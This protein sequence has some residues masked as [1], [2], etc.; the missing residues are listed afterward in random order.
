MLASAWWWC[1][2]SA[3]GQRC[4]LSAGLAN[5]DAGLLWLW[6][7][8]RHMSQ[9]NVPLYQQHLAMKQTASHVG[10]SKWRGLYLLRIACTSLPI[11]RLHSHTWGKLTHRRSYHLDKNGYLWR[12]IIKDQSILYFKHTRHSMC[13]PDM[14]YSYLKGY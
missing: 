12:L 10:S 13:Y 6:K 9:T 2:P 14:H 4:C 11:F 7:K 1:R 3:P 8:E 5:T